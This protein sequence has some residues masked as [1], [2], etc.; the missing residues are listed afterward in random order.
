VKSIITVKNIK[1][2]L[3]KNQIKYTYI[4]ND[5]IIINTFCSLYQLKDNSIT[6]ARKVSNVN[7]ET[8]NEYDNIIIVLGEEVEE[9]KLNGFIVKNPH[10]TYF[11]ILSYFF[12]EQPVIKIHP[13]AV[14]ETNKIGKNLSIGA[15]SFLGE[16]VELGDN[17]RISNNVSIE[18]NVK[19]GDNTIIESGVVIGV[20]GFGHY[21]EDNSVSV[22]VP[23]LGGVIIGESVAIGANCTVARGCLGNTVLE[24]YVKIDNLC[25]IA[26][27]VIIKTRTMIT[28][29][30]E[31]SGSTT[32]EEDVWVGP[33]SAINNGIIVGKNSFLGLGTVATKDV[34]AGK[35]VAGVPA[36]VLRDNNE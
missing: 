24:D 12:E 9:Q 26:H 28:A 1:D 13:T 16:L 21:K 30:T 27:N 3:T 19:I 15:N 32:I 29:C 4:G 23:H 20:S 18:G 10:R 17:V 33:A 14:V 7:F 2:Y 22:R 8:L 25:H 35:V 5:S 11:K 34:P 6:W 31:I 36:R